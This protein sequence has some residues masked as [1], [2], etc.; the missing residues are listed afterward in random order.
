VAERIDLFLTGPQV[1][2]SEMEYYLLILIIYSYK[3]I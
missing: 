1:K 2:Y 3:M